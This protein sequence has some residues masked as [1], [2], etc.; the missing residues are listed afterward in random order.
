[1]GE[2]GVRSISRIAHSGNSSRHLQ[3]PFN[4][5]TH[6]PH[7]SLKH[8]KLQV[9][10]KKKNQN[11]Q[12]KYSTNQI[13]RRNHQIP[14]IFSA[15]RVKLSH[16]QQSGVRV[17][18]WEK[19]RGDIGIPNSASWNLLITWWFK[20]DSFPSKFQGESLK[21]KRSKDYYNLNFACRP[22]LQ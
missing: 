2:D 15:Q 8:K 20:C 17:V 4:I 14:N 1:M 21:P 13:L 11:K 3:H 16:N 22:T 7:F 9:F 5:L 10:S 18:A 6:I 12:K 19:R